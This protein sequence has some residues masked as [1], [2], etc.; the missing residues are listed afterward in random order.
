MKVECFEREFHF[1]PVVGGQSARP[2]FE[3][4]CCKVVLHVSFFV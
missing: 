2:T 3:V 4:E 1:R